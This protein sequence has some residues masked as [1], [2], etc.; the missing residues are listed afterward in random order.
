M[1]ATHTLDAL[2]HAKPLRTIAIPGHPSNPTRTRWVLSGVL[3]S[4][5]ER[6]KLRAWKVGG[7][8]MTTE[9]AVD[10]FL[11]QLNCDHIDDHETP[12]AVARRGRDAGKALAALGY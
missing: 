2:E 8:L 7:R 3:N 6:V 4:R 11:S 1:S 5:G 10:Q 12:D 9:L